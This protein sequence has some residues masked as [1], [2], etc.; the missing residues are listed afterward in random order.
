V[1]ARSDKLKRLMKLQQTADSRRVY[2][3]RKARSYL[4]AEDRARREARL[5]ASAA[6]MAKLAQERAR[7]ALEQKQRRLRSAEA[8]QKRNEQQRRMLRTMSEQLLR[9]PIPIATAEGLAPGTTRLGGTRLLPLYQSE[10]LLGRIESGLEQNLPA[11]EGGGS[12]GGGGVGSSGVGSS[13][14]GGGGSGGGGATAST[15]AGKPGGS[16]WPGRPR[17]PPKR[18]SSALV[19]QMG[20]LEQLLTIPSRDGLRSPPRSRPTS[21]GPAARPSSAAEG[22]AAVNA[23]LGR[24]AATAGGAKRP[25]TADANGRLRQRPQRAPAQGILGYY[26]EGNLKLMDQFLW[27]QK[28]AGPPKLPR[29][30]LGM[31]LEYASQ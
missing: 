4:T 21:P 22:V 12:S 1:C 25:S 30:S 17:T 13:G 23:Q 27:K 10:R 11:V 7:E 15:P 3:D 2:R 31:Y 18:P 6:A 14:G 8:V 19:S 20:R 16:M 26:D 5:K 24:E 28:A 29:A 9:S